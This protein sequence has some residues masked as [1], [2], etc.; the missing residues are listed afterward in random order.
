[1]KIFLFFLS[2]SLWTI[3]CS[4]TVVKPLEPADSDIMTISL[5]PDFLS[6]SS[7]LEITA[8]NVFWSHN[9]RKGA[10]ELYA[11][12]D[13][14]TLLRTLKIDNATNED[15]EDM[16]KDEAGNLY[17]G[18]FGNND[19]DR[20]DLKIYKIANPQTHTLN[21]VTAEIINFTF[22]DQEAFP[23][24]EHEM[25]FDV[26]AMFIKG[27]HIFLLS[28]DRSKPFSG[29]TRLYQ[30]LN[31]PGNQVAIFLT[32]FDTDIKKNK[33]QITS[34]DISPD[35]KKLA[36][37]ANRTLWI[38]QNFQGNDFFSG[39][40]QRIN[41]VWDYQMEA[42]AFEDNQTVFLTNEKQGEEVARLHRIKL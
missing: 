29:K 19:N 2:L 8:P 17:V 34:A 35:G 18:D 20:R 25:H 32:E 38:F 14:G 33:G 5:L 11:F 21:N 27:S 4:Q 15:W 39:E 10:A 1:M 9:D 6:E 41:L 31:S 22:N 30:M 23:P 12:D 28:R 13:D 42:V 40:A 24:N 3:S 7:G 16:A 36:M 37:L 26:E